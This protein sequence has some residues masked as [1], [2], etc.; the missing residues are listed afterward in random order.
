M[1]QVL[2]QALGSRDTVTPDTSVSAAGEITGSAGG[3]EDPQVGVQ[4]VLEAFDL[5]AHVHVRLIIPAALWRV[6]AMCQTW[7]GALNGL[8][9]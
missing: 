3:A 4:L 2:C 6:L 5:G 9:C 1:W 7:G 8:P